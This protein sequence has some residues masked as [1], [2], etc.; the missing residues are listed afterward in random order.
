VPACT[1]TRRS[2]KT[3]PFFRVFLLCLSLKKEDE[4]AAKN[5][6]REDTE[7]AAHTEK[8]EALH[9]GQEK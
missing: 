8:A 4:K 3:T 7:K 6:I 1:N 5:A 2:S 9:L